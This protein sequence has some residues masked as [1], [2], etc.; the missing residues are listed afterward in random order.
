VLLVGAQLKGSPSRQEVES[1]GELSANG[2]GGKTC[3]QREAQA[4]VLADLVRAEAT[5]RD[6]PRHAIVLGGLND[7]DGT[8]L[9][10]AGNRPHSTVLSQ[11]TR[12]TEL[13]LH[14]LLSRL[15]RGERATWHGRYHGHGGPP[16]AGGRYDDAAMD[17]VLVSRGLLPYVTAVWIDRNLT[18][19]GASD[20]YPVVVELSTKTRAAKKK[21][22]K[23]RERGKEKAAERGAA[24]ATGGSWPADAARPAP[25]GLPGWLEAAGFDRVSLAAALAICGKERI[26]SVSDLQLRHDEGDLAGFGFPADLLHKIDVALGRWEQQTKMEPP[27][28]QK[29][30]TPE[31]DAK[32]PGHASEHSKEAHPKA[33]GA[34]PDRHRYDLVRCAPGENSKLCAE[35]GQWRQ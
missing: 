4:A 25:L 19:A 18:V 14:N 8:D 6:P 15:P 2:V 35:P 11:L 29:T 13:D 1:F 20:R 23:E 31:A 32:V 33:P 17:F 34:P 21:E 24:G 5:G 26:E 16:P 9:D 22:E 7:F 10:R 28:E 3:S 12:S 27:D 30:A